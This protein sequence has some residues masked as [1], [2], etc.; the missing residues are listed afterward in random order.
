MNKDLI[1]G[2][3]QHQA[4]GI[5]ATVDANAQAA[6]DKKTASVELLDAVVEAIRPAL[7]ALAS[8]IVIERV[9]SSAGKTEKTLDEPGIYVSSVGVPIL[10]R[11]G[12]RPAAGRWQGTDLFLC[13]E[14]SFVMLSY[15]GEVDRAGVSK[16]GAAVVELT[17]RD[18]VDMFNLTVVMDAIA[19]A[20]A[21][22]AGGNT[23]KRTEQ[24]RAQA[25][26][27]RALVTLVRSI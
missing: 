2:Q 10:D 15:D 17:T 16:W 27:L 11:P 8:R 18:V 26:R 6:V 19:R 25:T 4:V 14:G 12:P 23:G 20:M 22:Q 21:E 13:R 1:L 9:E 5:A 24:M 3:L 7:R